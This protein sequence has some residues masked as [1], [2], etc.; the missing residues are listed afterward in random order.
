MSTNYKITCVNSDLSNINIHTMKFISTSLLLLI[1]SILSLTSPSCTDDPDN[2][3]VVD[4]PVEPPVEQS[5]LAQRGVWHTPIMQDTSFMLINHIKVTDDKVIFVRQTGSWQN[6][7]VAT[8]LSTGKILWEWGS[9]DVVAGEFITSLSI[10]NDRVIIDLFGDIHIIDLNTGQTVW[11]NIVYQT[12]I[13]GDPRVSVANDQ[14][15]FTFSECGPNPRYN[16]MLRTPVT[17]FQPDTVF[18][19]FQITTPDPDSGW[20][21]SMEPPQAWID[22]NGDSILIFQARAFKLGI[23]KGKVDLYA[24]NLK[25]KS[26]KWYL[27]ELVE[28]GS[29]SIFPFSIEADRLYFCGSK[30]IFCINLND[31]NTI[32]KHK[33]TGFLEQT[34]DT[35][36]TI[37]ND[38]ILLKPRD[39]K[40]YAFDKF[41]GTIK[42]F[43]DNLGDTGPESKIDIINGVASFIGAPYLLEVNCE[44]R[45]LIN[46]EKSPNKFR[47]F[48]N[49]YEP[50]AVVK[51]KDEKGFI[52][53]DAYFISLYKPI[54]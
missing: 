41:T 8:E 49:N 47:N 45:T 53:A 31:G 50:G 20:V 6:T 23:N 21:T 27:K 19:I 28:E 48:S 30:S 39:R 11:E 24:Y 34:F 33:F 26:L 16:Y 22:S 9:P 5:S 40:F 7:V 18:R 43:K 14:I 29:S 46:K 2:P 4:P 42:W 37:W 12:G 1:C 52:T 38:L 54:K 10:W 13:C 51:T 44:E 17:H 32:W 15:Y 35:A 3:I 25:T 36:P